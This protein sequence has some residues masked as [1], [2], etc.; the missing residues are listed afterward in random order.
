MNTIRNKQQPVNDSRPKTMVRLAIKGQL[1]KNEDSANYVF[2][3]AEDKQ[4]LESIPTD[5]REDIQALRLEANNIE[6]F[7]LWYNGGRIYYAYRRQLP[8]RGGSDC[9]MVVVCSDRMVSNGV[10]LV[11]VLRDVFDY[12]IRLSSSFDI[13]DEMIQEKLSGLT[14]VPVAALW[15][16]SNR[17][18]TSV[19]LKNAYRAYSDED[20]LANILENPYQSA[21]AR[22]N[23]ILIVQKE[24]LSQAR[25]NIDEITTNVKQD[26][27]VRNSNDSTLVGGGNVIEVGESFRIKYL[28]SGYGDVETEPLRIGTQSKYFKVDGNEIVV[29]SALEAG[30]SFKKEILLK[31]TDE[32]GN[33]LANWD[34]RVKNKQGNYSSCKLLDKPGYITL[35]DGTYRC[36]IFA[37]G[38]EIREI[39]IDAGTVSTFSVKMESKGIE[40]EFH[41]LPAWRKPFAKTPDRKDTIKVSLSNNNLFYKKYKE[42]LEGY[43]RSFYVSKTKPLWVTIVFSL[44]MLVVGFCIGRGTSMESETVMNDNNSSS[45][46]SSNNDEET[47][48]KKLNESD[49]WKAN[50]MKS[51]KYKDLLENLM[52]NPDRVKV[53]DYVGITNKEWKKYCRVKNEPLCS[54][55]LSLRNEQLKASRAHKTIEWENVNRPDDEEED[56]FYLLKSDKWETNKIKSQRYKTMMEDLKKAVNVANKPDNYKELGT[57]KKWDGYLTYA[58]KVGFTYRNPISRMLKSSQMIDWSLW[59][60]KGDYIGP[61]S[62]R[63]GSSATPNPDAI[64]MLQD[65]L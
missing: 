54:V 16:T 9:A 48:L 65:R 53:D 14:L 47:D 63:A 10:M 39:M 29:S 26:Y 18:Q 31:V 17:Q 64:E 11:S 45:I 12:C 41:L 36:Q 44:L 20:E 32:L 27:F 6:C 35:P 49:V 46:T 8:G 33:P 28:K 58:P 51:Q 57:N 5:S 34:C 50:E 55:E 40:V 30:V 38:Y 3:K 43:P 1:Y 61:T 23:R 52:K 15:S 42:Q 62:E 24:F 37:T 60:D 19:E 25:P 2:P 22:Y 4:W 56:L 21:Y 59:N 7:S 13:Q